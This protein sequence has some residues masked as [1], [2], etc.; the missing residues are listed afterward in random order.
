MTTGDAPPPLSP[1]E[2]A[3]R[4][5]FTNPDSEVSRAAR[6]REARQAVPSELI[7][8]R[9]PPALRAALEAAAEAAQ[10]TLSSEIRYR[11]QRSLIIPS[12]LGETRRLVLAAAKAGV[13]AEQ[14]AKLLEIHTE[15]IER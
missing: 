14:I 11:L 10:R 3:E 4:A 13:S 12:M 2:A 6:E 1:A 15:G 5:Q 7:A 9:A 8:F